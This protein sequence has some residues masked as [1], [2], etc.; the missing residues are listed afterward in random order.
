MPV[1]R[2]RGLLPYLDLAYQGY[3]D[4]IEQDAFAR[5]RAGRR[6]G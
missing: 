1:L 5:A 3:G 6:R 2:E 4:G